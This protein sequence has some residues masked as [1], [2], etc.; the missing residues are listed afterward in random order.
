MICDCKLGNVQDESIVLL[1]NVCV[2]FVSISV[3]VFD[4]VCVAF[5]KTIL[6][7]VASDI[8]PVWIVIFVKYWLVKKY[9]IY[10]YMLYL[11]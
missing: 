8:D 5:G 3:V 10:F 7:F 1:D 9:L 6:A 11:Y 4:I 2:E